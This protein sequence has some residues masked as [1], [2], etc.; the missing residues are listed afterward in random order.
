MKDK[1]KN[2]K[3]MQ[4]AGFKLD[5]ELSNGDKVW[6]RGGIRVATGQQPVSLKKLIGYVIDQAVDKARTGAYVSFRPFETENKSK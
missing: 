6:K 2:K 3:L 1:D 5:Y 4:S